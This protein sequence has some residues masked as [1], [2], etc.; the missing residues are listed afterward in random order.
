MKA[1]TDALYIGRFRTLA[2]RPAD[3]DV[4]RRELLGLIVEETDAASGRI[5]QRDHEACWREA[6]SVGFRRATADAGAST[7]PASLDDVRRRRQTL[8][9]G[10]DSTTR[11]L[12]PLE[13]AGNAIVELTFADAP[14]R[15]T[16]PIS[17]VLAVAC[18]AVERH[19][20]LEDQRW[21]ADQATCL[22]LERDLREN[23]LACRD[24]EEV[25]ATLA[26]DARVLVGA[27]RVGVWLARGGG[28]R[29][30]SMSGQDCVP[31]RSDLVEAM[32]RVV[33]EALGGGA[34]TADGVVELAA[35]AGQAV[36]STVWTAYRTRFG[37]RTMIVAPL[38]LGD[39]SEGRGV[40][41]GAIV[42]EFLEAS[43]NEDSS[44]VLA[45]TARTGAR[46]A[47]LHDS[48]GRRPGLRR[49]LGR[50]RL[51]AAAVV[52]TVGILLAIPMPA[53]VACRG[54]LQ[55]A[56]KQ[57]VFAPSLGVVEEIF[58]D[59]GGRVAEG[60]MLLRL[61][62][63][64]LETEST[65]L[66]GELA[67]G[68]RRLAAVMR[69]RTLGR[70]PS[71]G[72]DDD[73]ALQAETVEL[74]KKLEA[75]ERESAICERELAGLTIYAPTSG[76]V[77][78]SNLRELLNQRPV[79]RGQVLLTICRLDGP[80]RLELQAA[81]SD[82]GRLAGAL[83]ARSELEVDFSRASDPF[84]DHRARLVAGPLVARTTP[85][86]KTVLVVEAECESGA[87]PY[88]GGEVV[89]RIHTGNASLGSQMFGGIGRMI[90]HHVL[91][92]W[93]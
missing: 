19:S 77:S 39:R 12:H 30:K 50:R 56:E 47:A 22:R 55:P 20:Q 28:L 4:F 69:L 58:V 72:R 23:L 64:A 88:E 15:D 71:T 73:P 82:G 54:V 52:A 81:E 65:R 11:V 85:E 21:L 51:V 63:V 45:E 61:R 87:A 26:N 84:T 59:D 67:A 43:P 24:T 29:L 6:E 32:A 38:N 1:A 44:R 93:F 74:T 8:I 16:R 46:A 60:Q 86:G 49:L 90:R 79:A 89:A 36:E 41:A 91:F 68:Q 31:D 2:E 62:S 70:K 10:R 33:A 75:L 13:P 7:E 80:W 25:A 57:N 9:V 40:P 17:R 14:G 66:Q 83:E 34:R 5:W 27:D 76:I 37:V 48:H 53:D 18:A 35:P 78:T 42:A 3:R 92:R